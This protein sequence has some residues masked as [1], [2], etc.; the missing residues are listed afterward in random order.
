VFGRYR[1]PSTRLN[2][3]PVPGSEFGAEADF[4]MVP[5]SR[6][7]IGPAVSVFSRPTGVD[8]EEA[9]LSDQDRFGTLRVMNVQA[10][11]KAQVGT[12][13]GATLNLS[14]FH[15]IYAVNNP[16][17]F[18]AGLGVSWVDPFRHKRDEET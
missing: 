2:D 10:G 14:V 16:L 15:S 3:T 1:L 7:G 6:V 4:V 18:S 12:V 17:V 8:F 11:L 5:D 9:D 13:G